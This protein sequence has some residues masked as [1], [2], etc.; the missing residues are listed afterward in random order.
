MEKKVVE[1]E[2]PPDSQVDTLDL[3]DL[4]ALP[5]KVVVLNEAS[6][7]STGQEIVWIN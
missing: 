6:G 7:G 1:E 4:D 3:D 5:H 2:M